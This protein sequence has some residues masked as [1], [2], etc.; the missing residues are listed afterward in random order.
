MYYQFFNVYIDIN[1][2][3]TCTTGIQDTDKRKIERSKAW[4][5]AGLWCYFTS[6]STELKASLSLRL[7]IK[8]SS[9]I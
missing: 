5:S 9:M 8:A 3:K 1:Y 4:C 2:F 6:V 7:P